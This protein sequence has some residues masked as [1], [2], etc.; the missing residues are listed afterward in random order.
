MK[1]WIV[2]LLVAFLLGGGTAVEGQGKKSTLLR[3]LM[4]EKLKSSQSLLEG[5]A[6]GDV[7]KITRSAEKLIQLSRR[8]EWFVYRTPQFE[9]HSNEFRRAAETIA[10]KARDKNL[11]GVALAYLDLTLTCVRCHRYVREVRDARL[12]QGRD[13][14]LTEK[15]E[16]FP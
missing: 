1:N 15:K 10:A 4:A 11:D 2:G 3:E 8:E 14:F 5:L 12:P 7:D 13:L 16:K 9:M 6:L